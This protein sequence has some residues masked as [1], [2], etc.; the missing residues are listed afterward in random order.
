VAALVEKA[1][2]HVSA[3]AKVADLARR[4][5][6]RLTKKATWNTQSRV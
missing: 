2:R 1:A 4:P 5:S 3:A 6:R